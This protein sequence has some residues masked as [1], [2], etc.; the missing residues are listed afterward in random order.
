MVAGAVEQALV[1]DCHV[2]T[3]CL[4][5][6]DVYGFLA[7][8]APPP[9]TSLDPDRHIFITGLGKSVSASLRIG[10]T[11]S[12]EE[13]AARIAAVVW[14]NT[15]FTSPAMA[16]VSATWIEDGTAARVASPKR[17]M[18]A[19]RQ[20]IARRLLANRVTGAATAPP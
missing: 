20:R 8:D 16:E 1:D 14:A 9:I 10:Y 13:L 18:I 12:N 5:S 3:L 19:L 4:Q 11:V 6:I 15:Y 7:P 2:R 17:E